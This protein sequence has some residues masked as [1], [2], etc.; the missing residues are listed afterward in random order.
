L[1]GSPAEAGHVPEAE[2]VVATG[3]LGVG[4]VLPEAPLPL[5]QA[6]T[7]KTTTMSRANKRL[8]MCVFIRSSPSPLMPPQDAVGH[9]RYR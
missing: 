9:V 2:P 8:Y 6:T 7:P 4:D 3:A 5:L 1:A